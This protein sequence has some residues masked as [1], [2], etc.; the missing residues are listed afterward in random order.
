MSLLHIVQPQDKCTQ[1]PLGKLAH[2]QEPGYDRYDCREGKA[3]QQ[4]WHILKGSHL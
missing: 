1:L 3:V 4:A 2:Q